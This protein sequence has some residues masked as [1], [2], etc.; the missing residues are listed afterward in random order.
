MRRLLLVVMASLWGC[1]PTSA[2]PRS[3]ID[4]V[5][6]GQPDTT[7][8]SVMLL[9][10]RYD[11]GQA[12]VCSAVLISPRV[13]M[14]AAHCVDASLR[15]ATTVVVKATDKPDSANLHAADFIT[16]TTIARHPGWNPASMPS[17]DDLAALLLATS[18]GVAPSPML[19]ALPADFVGKAIRISGYGRTAAGTA[20][21]G[22]RRTAPSTV[23]SVSAS[24]FQFGVTGVA[25]ACVGDSGGPT[26]LTGSDGVERVA[27]VHSN[28]DSQCGD[29][30]DIRLD[31]HLAFIDAFVAANDP[32]A[33]TGDGRCASGCTPADPDCGPDCTTNGQCNPACTP[34]DV[35]C[36]CQADGTCETT[37]PPGKTDPDCG[38]MADAVCVA[39]CVS[40][41]DC[42]DCGMNDVCSP[43]TCATPDPDCL[44]DGQVCQLGSQCAG[45]QCVPDRRGFSFCSRAC[46]DTAQCQLDFVCAGGH[47]DVAAVA[48]AE[49][50]RGSCASVES[51][52]WVLAL[53]TL[54]RRA[55]PSAR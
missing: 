3:R 47:C 42:V 8:T 35:D 24:V 30:E 25:G 53:V 20:D 5:L 40:D 17:P 21:S 1:E 13:L 23:T 15:G 27:G 7:T 10:L 4:A 34:T 54:L 29:T 6:A 46:T 2:V 39:S 50:V 41:P 38:C 26:F 14:T 52:G 28:G 11:N 31:S 32:P 45:H 48:Q 51:L 22:T 16:V 37:C 49:P 18:P 36:L 44:L 19:R 33:C 9:D 12:G 43:L 55:R